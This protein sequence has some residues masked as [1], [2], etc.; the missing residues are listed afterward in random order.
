[1]S[2]LPNGYKRKRK[3]YIQKND[4]TTFSLNSPYNKEVTNWRLQSNNRFWF[5]ETTNKWISREQYYPFNTD[6]VHL[7]SIIAVIKHLR[8]QHLP[9]RITFSLQGKYIGQ[10]YTIHVI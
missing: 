5:N 7:K 10:H 8:K 9:S 1:M 3:I 6:T 4:R 2:V